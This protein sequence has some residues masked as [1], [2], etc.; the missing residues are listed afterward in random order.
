MLQEYGNISYKMQHDDAHDDARNANIEAKKLG[1]VQSKK[2][3]VTEDLPRT[4]VPI[5]SIDLPD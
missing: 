5:V 3:V 2:G 1:T 4:V